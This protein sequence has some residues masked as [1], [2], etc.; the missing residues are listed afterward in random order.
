MGFSVTWF[1]HRRNGMRAST[2]LDRSGSVTTH[3]RRPPRIIVTHLALLSAL[4]ILGACATASEVK[5]IAGGESVVAQAPSFRAGE[6]WNWTGGPYEGYLRVLALEADGSIVESNTDIWCRDGCRYV[7]DKNGI[8]TSGTNKKGESAY[9]SG[10]RILDFPLRVGKEWTQTIN[11]A[12]SDG[13]VRPF[14]NRWR[15]EA[16]EEVT[17]KA[18]TFKAF[19]ISWYQENRGPYAWNGRASLWWSPEVKAFVKRVAHTSGFGSDVELASY[20]VK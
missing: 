19:R 9:V 10:L 13:T 7:R 18:G 17:V 12:Q 15:V 6:E 5:P 8:A 14:F 1:L 11:L 16:F 4:L 2:A 20:V 3:S